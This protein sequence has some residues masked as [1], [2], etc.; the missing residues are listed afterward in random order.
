MAGCLDFLFCLI[1][2]GKQSFIV[3]NG[4]FLGRVYGYR[5]GMIQ[6]LCFY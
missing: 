3:A 4:I 6:I 1:V 2:R 5:G